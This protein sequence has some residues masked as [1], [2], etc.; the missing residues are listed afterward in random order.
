MG[1]GIKTVPDDCP[2]DL[3]TPPSIGSEDDLLELGIGL[4]DHWAMVPEA[5]SRPESLSAEKII[6]GQIA[7]RLCDHKDECTQAVEVGRSVGVVERDHPDQLE[8][9]L[10]NEEKAKL[11]ANA[12]VRKKVEQGFTLQSVANMAGAVAQL[13]KPLRDVVVEMIKA[14]DGISLNSS[15][16]PEELGSLVIEGKDYTVIGWSGARLIISNG[17]VEVIEGE[18]K[19]GSVYGSYGT[20]VKSFAGMLRSSQETPET[21]FLSEFLR[22]GGNLRQL[23]IKKL[24]GVDALEFNASTHSMVRIYGGIFDG[25]RSL[26]ESGAERVTTFFIPEAITGAKSGDGATTK[27]NRAAKQAASLL[28]EHKGMIRKGEAEKLYSSLKL[29]KLELA[30]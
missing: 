27:V 18:V 28:T 5:V 3:S 2:A 22:G 13:P 19:K 9:M 6:A 26:L 20:L 4:D 21:S 25:P 30:N 7:C 10:T 14:D 12:A 29:R 17:V 15:S 16:M 24:N 1:L 8:D 23:N 11:W